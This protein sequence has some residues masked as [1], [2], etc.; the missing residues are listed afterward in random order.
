[1]ELTDK[2]YEILMNLYHELS[3]AF[4]FLPDDIQAA[5]YKR[6]YQK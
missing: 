3:I 1:M 6:L 5:F 2:Q 4:A